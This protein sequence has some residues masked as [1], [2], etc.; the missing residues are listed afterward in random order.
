MMIALTEGLL[1]NFQTNNISSKAGKNQGAMTHYSIGA[2]QSIFIAFSA[3][4]LL[5][6]FTQPTLAGDSDENYKVKGHVYEEK[7]NG[8]V[9]KATI[10]DK[11]EV[12]PD[13]KNPKNLYGD[14]VEREEIT[15]SQ[16]AHELHRNQELRDAGGSVPHDLCIECNKKSK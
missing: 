7:D 12:N 14:R 6:P 10:F 8:K 13:S 9:E 2:G 4:M 3:L 5:A 16:A 1:M 11:K 15:K